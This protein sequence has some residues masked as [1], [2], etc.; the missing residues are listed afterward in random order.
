[1]DEKRKV[2]WRASLFLLIVL[3]LALALRLHGIGT[4]DIWGDEAFS[5]DLSLRPLPQVV[6][7]AADTHPP[8][9]PL[10][11]FFW[12]RLAGTSAFSTRLLSALVGT[13]VVPLLWALA[14]RL[15]PKRP[16]LPWVAAILATVSPLLIYYSQE[17]RMYELVTALALVSVYFTLRLIPAGTRNRMGRGTAIAYWFSTAAALYTHYYAFFV[18]AAENLFVLARLRKDRKGLARW[19]LLQLLLIAAYVPWIV[20]QS[21][22]LGS[23]ASTRFEEWGWQ[24]IELI[25][26]K[27]L[28]AFSNGLTTD[29]PIAQIAGAAFFV[30]IA[31][32]ILATVR[33]K[34]S[35][36]W[37]APTYM[38]VPVFIAWLVNP[39]LPFFYERY[40]LLAL[41]GFYLVAALGLD[42]LGSRALPL[43]AGAVVIAVALNAYS[44]SNYYWNDAYAKGKYGQMMAFVTSHAQNGD[45]LILNNPLQ[46]PLFK[47]Y[48]PHGVPAF[49]LPDGAPL[50]DPSTR[51][52]LAE[53]A[54]THDR[55]WLVMYGNPAEYDPTGYLERWLGANAYKS[56]FRGYVDASLSLYVMPS[57]SSAEVTHSTDVTLG[58]H[59]RLVGYSLDRTDLKPGETI[60]LALHWQ[61]DSTIDRRYTVFTHLIADPETGPLNPETGSTVWAQMDSEPVGGARPTTGWKAG[62]AIDDFYGLELPGDIPPGVYELEVGMY[63]PVTLQRLQA[64]DANGQ[65]LKQDRVLLERISVKDK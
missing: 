11:L 46:K 40:V 4:Q 6:A 64:F 55:L 34:R 21:S 3:L 27:T 54:H 52:Q 19:A 39:I 15:D 43:A 41:P 12:L 20:V 16:R 13:L 37:L 42:E 17:T 23:K 29:F 10:L 28:L 7:G 60:R 62:E 22:F 45:A 24:G 18:L 25:F 58:D 63:D 35:A 48:A 14:R 9:Y 36:L 26:G 44:L 53:I 51:Q 2:S 50:E 5:I 32:G 33:G 56:L 30:T 57:S 1:M 61:T 59:I 65:R 38:V 47:Y 31:L 8:F 49:F